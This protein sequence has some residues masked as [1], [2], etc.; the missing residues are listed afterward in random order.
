MAILDF[1]QPQQA[2]IQQFQ[3]WYLQSV[4]VPVAQRYSLTDEYAYITPA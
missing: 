4:V 2:W 1:H 3:N